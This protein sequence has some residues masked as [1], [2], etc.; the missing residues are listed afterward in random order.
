MVQCSNVAWAVGRSG[1]G[2][3]GFGH[4]SSPRHAVVL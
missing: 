3:H 1:A 4:L 2:Q